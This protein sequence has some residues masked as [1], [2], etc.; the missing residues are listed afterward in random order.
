MV[1]DL[2]L[3]F[4]RFHGWHHAA[5]VLEA[6]AGE[7]PRAPPRAALAAAAGLRTPPADGLPLLYALLPDNER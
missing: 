5:A 6:E 7:L 4:V 3:D 1:L 2:V